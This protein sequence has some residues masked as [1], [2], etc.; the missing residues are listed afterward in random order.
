MDLYLWRYVGNQA[1]IMIR[2]HACIKGH[3]QYS[4]HQT[5]QS[6]KWGASDCS[7]FAKWPS[8]PVVNPLHAELHPICHLLALLGAHHIF[9]VSRIRINALNAELHPIC[10][11]LI[12]LGAHHIFHVSRIRVKLCSPEKLETI[13]FCMIYFVS[14]CL[15]QFLCNLYVLSDEQEAASPPTLRHI[16]TRHESSA[17]PLWETEVPCRFIGISLWVQLCWYSRAD[18]LL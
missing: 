18:W 6:L 8:V 13:L 7:V 5:R 16:S 10:H 12:L 15:C 3:S 9:H 11:L 14:S 17:T 4:C 1:T 2:Q